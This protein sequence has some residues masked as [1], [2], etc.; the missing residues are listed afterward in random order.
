MVA[1]KFGIVD[2]GLLIAYGASGSFLADMTNSFAQ[3]FGLD[4]APLPLASLPTPVEPAPG[5]GDGV[6]VKRDDRT[7]ASHGGNKIRKLAFLLAEHDGRPL[8]TMGPTGSNW[9]L[10][11]ALTC[12]S[13]GLALEVIQFPMPRYPGSAAKDLLIRQQAGSLTATGGYVRATARLLAAGRAG[14]R[15]LPA[16]GSDALGTLAYVA[17]AFELAGQVEAGLL[18]EP[19]DLYVAY[20]SGGTAVGLAL[21]LALSGMKTRLRAV[22]VTDRALSNPLMAGQLGRGALRL[23]G[24]DRSAGELLRQRVDWIHDQFG[25]GY[26]RYT[27]RAAAAGRVAAEAGLD[28]EPVYTGKTLAGLLADRARGRA[29][30]VSLFWLTFSGH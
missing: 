7:A 26:A 10:A 21:G 16:G 22:R 4:L 1:P 6:W 30:P 15:T 8:A 12:R 9:L 24:L 25:P 27:A 18:P 23:L 2:C 5:L 20:G 13:L 19:D 28:L 17:A 29:G 3:R 11:A 14:A